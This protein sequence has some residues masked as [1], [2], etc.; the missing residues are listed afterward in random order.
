MRLTNTAFAAHYC[1]MLTSPTLLKEID[2][3]L[4]RYAVVS[5]VAYR[6]LTKADR[7]NVCWRNA[8]HDQRSGCNGEKEEAPTGICPHASD[9]SAAVIFL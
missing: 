6:Q 9:A 3:F 4:E 7:P 8:C 1:G 2:R 5:A